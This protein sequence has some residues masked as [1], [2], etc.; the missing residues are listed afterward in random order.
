MQR[1]TKMTFDDF[2]MEVD[3]QYHGFI[4]EIHEY[5]TENGCTLKVTTAKSGCMVSYQYGKKKRVVLNFVFRKGA[6]Q[7]RIYCGHVDQYLETIESL[8]ES[9]R[10]TIEKAP[11]CKRFEDPPKC[12]PKC[13]G[14][15]FPL[16]GTHHQKCRYFSF[17]FEVNNETIP[18]IRKMLEKEVACRAAV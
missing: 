7:A 5:L 13:I 15:V 4:C 17:F 18:S 6:L 8:P 12:S 2:L 3:P 10:K 16:A 11:K 14:Y 1:G 9:M